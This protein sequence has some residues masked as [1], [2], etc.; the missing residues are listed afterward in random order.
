MSTATDAAVPYRDRVRIVWPSGELRWAEIRAAPVLGD[1]KQLSY[2]GT[3][4]DLTEA[5]NAQ[6][7]RDELQ[8]RLHAQTERLFGYRRDELIG[9]PAEILVPDAIKASHPA[10]RAGYVAEPRPRPMG[11]GLE[12]VARHRDGST[13]RRE[14]SLSTIDTGTTVYGIIT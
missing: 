2:V 5:V 7:Q 9:Q 12:L 4:E 3:V 6:R 8:A 14:I 11:K 13:F 10:Y 1:G